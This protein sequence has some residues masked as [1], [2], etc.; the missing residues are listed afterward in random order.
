MVRARTAA[1]AR[2][3]V[4]SAFVTALLLLGAA[5]LGGALAPPAAAGFAPGQVWMWH[6]HDGGGGVDDRFADVARAP[7]GSLYACGTTDFDV[8]VQAGQLQLVK[9]DA[10]GDTVWTRTATVP[11]VTVMFAKAVSVD[12]SGAATVVA[13]FVKD[14]YWDMFVAKWNAAGT[15]Q[16]TAV[17]GSADPQ[18]DDE[19]ADVVAN[20]AGDV[21]VCGS[22]GSGSEVAV[23][24]YDSAADPAHPMQGLEEWTHHT[25]GTVFTDMAHGQGI[26]IDPHG[27]VY[28]TGNR[29]MKSGG[30]NLY[31]EK[32][33]GGAGGSLW[34]RGWD[35]AAHQHDTGL[36]VRYR[37]GAVYVG[38]ET[39]TL[40]HAGDIVVLRYAART[41]TRSWVRTWDNPKMHQTDD[42]SDLRVD[43]HGNVSVAGLSYYL[44]AVKYKALLVRV[45]RSGSVAWWRTYRDVPSNGYAGWNTLAV[46]SSGTA[47][48]AGFARTATIVQMTV[49][50]YSA[51]GRRVWLTTWDGPPPAYAGAD[52]TACV[53]SGSSDLVVVGSS[54]VTPTYD[55]AAAVW[56]RR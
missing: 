34:L 24:K 33:R 51:A 54:V 27:D 9:Y 11:G 35:G 29:V 45:R 47:Y 25:S 6:A 53:F 4:V 8:G 49:A 56:L 23:V 2:A 46:S 15:P 40:K 22:M 18:L 52:A 16:W 32:L 42:L 12:P 30:S 3:L 20:A 50:R 10:A 38:G 5:A 14:G 28:V 1:S 31:V 44:T 7:D 37:D 36:V 39:Q 43:G 26:A 19:A 48:V 41:G 55:D 13:S 17:K 21:F